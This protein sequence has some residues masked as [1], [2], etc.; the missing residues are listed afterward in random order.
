MSRLIGFPK[1]L[2]FELVGYPSEYPKY[3]VRIYERRALD[4]KIQ[5]KNIYMQLRGRYLSDSHKDED[6]HLSKEEFSE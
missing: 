5:S 2:I 3:Y 1:I 6:G 4:A